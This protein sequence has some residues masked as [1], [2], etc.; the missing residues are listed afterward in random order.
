MKKSTL[1]LAIAISSTLTLTACG[2]GGSSGGS[3]AQPSTSVIKPNTGTNTAQNNGTQNQNTGKNTAQTGNNSQNGGNNNTGSTGNTQSNTN[4]NTNANHGTIS[5][6]AFIIHTKDNIEAN[7]S[8][9]STNINTLNVNGNTFRLSSPNTTAGSF[10]TNYTE[11][12]DSVISGTHVRHA[13]YGY[14]SDVASDKEYFFYQGTKTPVANIPTKGIANYEGHSFYICADCDDDYLGKSKFTADFGKKT[15]TGSVSND[16]ANVA[17]N[18]TIS[19]NGFSGTTN[20]TKVDG[21][22]FG[23]NAQELAGY[24]LNE[25]QKFGGGFGAT[26]K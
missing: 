26:K 5:G 24:Y 8:N 14:I 13:K 19:G 21:A 1:T 18:A 10:V 6:K 20:G 23:N 7:I 3:T 16:H 25:S 2:G 17:L 12:R 15:L 9:T 22:F 4:K 11:Q